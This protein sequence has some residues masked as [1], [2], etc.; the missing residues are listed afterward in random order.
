MKLLRHKS[1]FVLLMAISSAA[2]ALTSAPAVVVDAANPAPQ[3]SV[4][5]PT[6]SSF[7]AE[8]EALQKEI[9]LLQS[10]EQKVKLEESISSMQKKPV[11][12]PVKELNAAKIAA[13]IE[14]K[15]TIDVGVQ[16]IYGV[17]NSFQA[18]LFY[19][20]AQLT[21]KRGSELN[22]D[23]KVSSITATS[24]HISNGETDRTL[25]LSSTND[26]KS[27]ALVAPKPLGLPSVPF[28]VGQ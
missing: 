2:S 10:K 17:G 14:A 6:D 9:S 19:R 1:T 24:V 4:P 23:W 16:A 27:S 12:D 20:G 7:G 8:L 25:S 22:G 18:V 21:V 13:K 28:Q 26:V 3:S 11:L 15:N 5:V